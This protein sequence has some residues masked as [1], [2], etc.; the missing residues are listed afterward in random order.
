MKRL[1]SFAA[2]L[3]LIGSTGLALAQVTTPVAGDSTPGAEG[4]RIRNP[5]M[6][7]IVDRIKLQE[8]RIA[9]G[10]KNAKLT[11]DEAAA[12]K[13]KLV[14]IRDEIKADFKLNRENG[15]KGITDDQIKQ[16]NTELDA[17]SAAIHDEKQGAAAPASTPANP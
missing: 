7:M 13:A 16:I 8:D 9:M 2:S 1:V 4:T 11:A 14:S 17:N 10:V 15:Q 12:L 3:L 5:K 6:K